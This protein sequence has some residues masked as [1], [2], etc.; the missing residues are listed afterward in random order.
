M[1]HALPLHQLSAGEVE[2][3]W[4]ELGDSAWNECLPELWRVLSA[5][6]VER[7]RA[8]KLETSARDFIL[9]RGILRQLLSR[10]TGCSPS[11]VALSYTSSGKPCVCADAQRLAFNLSHSGG[12]AIYAFSRE[13]VGV[14]IESRDSGHG[15]SSLAFLFLSDS[16]RLHLASVPENDREPV[17]LRIWTRKEGVLKGS[18]VGLI[19]EMRHITVWRGPGTTMLSGASLHFNGIDWII[20]DVPYA[21]VLASVA[22]PKMDHGDWVIKRFRIIPHGGFFKDDGS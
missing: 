6:E 5:D 22:L 7:A 20:Y 2:L 3:H 19:D 10:Y 17:C 8:F 14:D 16:E 4:M 21:N 13:T 11:A 15:M 9:C 1:H 12:F 18:G